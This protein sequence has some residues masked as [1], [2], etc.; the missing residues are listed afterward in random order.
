MRTLH[1]ALIKP[2]HYDDDGYVIQWYRSAMPSNSLGTV[3]GVA[4]DCADRKVLGDDVEIRVSAYD[5]SNTRIRPKKIARRIRHEGGVGLYWS[6]DFRG[7]SGWV[8]VPQRQADRM[9]SPSHPDGLPRRT[10]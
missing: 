2:S 8:E 9:S 4:A 6:S 3:H 10:R 7:P 1:L 5:E